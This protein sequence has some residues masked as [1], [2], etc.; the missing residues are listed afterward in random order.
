MPA[1]TPLDDAVGFVHRH[2]RPRVLRE[3][4]RA[5]RGGVHEVGEAEGVR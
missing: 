5:L 2:K 4:D 3:V 1:R